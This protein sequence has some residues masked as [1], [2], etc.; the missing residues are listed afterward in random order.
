MYEAGPS[1][2]ADRSMRIGAGIHTRS[3]QRT[4]MATSFSLTVLRICWEPGIF[5]S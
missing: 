1:P 3:Q 2:R 4:A 5:L